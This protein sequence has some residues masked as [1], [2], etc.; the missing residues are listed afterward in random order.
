MRFRLAAVLLGFVLLTA[1]P[2][3]AQVWDSPMLAPPAP[4]MG[5]GFYLFEP[6]G[7]DLGL[8]GT[9]RSPGTRNI[10]VRFGLADGVGGDDVA[11]VF[12]GDYSSL[13][14]GPTPDFPLQVGWVIGAGL[15][16]ADNLSF[17]APFGATFGVPLDLEDLRLI[18]YVTP[19]VVFDAY[20][21]NDDADA[22]SDLNFT[23][24]LGLDVR[25]GPT[26]AIRF[27]ATLIDRD[28]VAIG[29]VF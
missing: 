26:W 5:Y 4:E 17:S 8:L 28:A 10:R 15:A 18:P 24:D 22:D 11:V 25:V 7:A 16:F 14:R 27:G 12:G 1:A 2:A 3:S 9:W 19:R 23:M 13:L 6:A 20:F 29:V 21:G